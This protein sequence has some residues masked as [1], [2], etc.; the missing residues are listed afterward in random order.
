MKQ[1]DRAQR[2]MPVPAL[3]GT[4][5]GSPDRRAGVKGGAFALMVWMTKSLFPMIRCLPWKNTLFL[6]YYPERRSDNTG[7]TGILE[8]YWGTMKITIWQGDST[9]ATRP[10]IHHRF[11]E[12]QL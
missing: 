6:L 7:F 1:W 2:S 10:Y 4:I 3:D 12:G 8:G 9:H 5:S 11:T